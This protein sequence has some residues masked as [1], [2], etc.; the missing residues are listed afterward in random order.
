MNNRKQTL[1]AALCLLFGVGT[2][3]AVAQTDK[4]SL[5]SNPSF[6]SG[7]VDWSVLQMWKQTNT[8]FAK[9]GNVY[10]EKWVSQGSRAGDAQMFQTI[11]NMPNGRYQLVVAAQNVQQN[12]TAVQTGAWIVANDSRVEV[13]E[14]GDYTVEFTVIEKEATIGF[15]AVG[16]TGNY[17]CCDNFRL[18]LLDDDIAVLKA[19]LQNRIDAAEELLEQRLALNTPS[20][21]I[22]DFQAAIDAAKAE[23][24][25]DTDANYVTVAMALKRV[26]LAF[27][28]A[29]ATGTVPAV[30][31]HSYVARGATMAFGRST[32]SGVSSSELLEQGFCWATHPEPTV[33]DNRSTKY[34]TQNGRIYM[35]DN[36]TPS[37][38]YYVRAY[39]MTK[40][41]AVGY[42][43]AVK[44][45]TLPKGNVGWSYNN[46]GSAEENVRINIAVADAVYYLNQ[47]TSINGLYTQVNYGSGTPTADCS[48]GGWMRVGPNA[49]YQ[50]TGTILHEL[51][52]AI[53]VGQHD[54]W[55]GGN[56]PLR[57]G[58][59][60]GDWLGERA[61]AV[62]RFLDN[63]TTS[64]M[65]GDDVHMWPYGINGAH[66]D[67]DAPMLHMSSV[68]IF[69]ALG[70]DGLPPTGGFATPAYTFEQEDTVKYYI[71]NESED[72]GLYTSYLVVENGKVV[73]KA[74]T[75]DDAVA[76]DAAAWYVTFNPQ[77]SYYQLR[78]ASTG[79][80][81]AHGG[82]TAT[83]VS[84]NTNFHMMR[85]RVD[86][87]VGNA[88]KKVNVRGYWLVKPQHSLN[89]PC[90]SAAADGKV[91]SATFD[92]TDGAHAQRWVFLTED[93][94]EEVEEAA[95]G[96]FMSELDEWTLR[97]EAFMNTPHT[98][99]V[100]GTDAAFKVVLDMLKEKQGQ[101]LTTTEIAACV[102]EA[103]A[104]ILEF[105][106]NVTPTDVNQPFDITYLIANAAI[107]DA[108]GWS[109][110]PTLNHS[111]MEYY[112]TVFDFNQ[113]TTAKLPKGVY[114]L[115]VQ[116]FQRPG[117]AATVYDA[118]T[119]GSAI[120][121]SEIY[122]TSS[123]KQKVMHIAA[124][125]QK[126]KLG[127]TESAV[128]S[129][130]RYIPND[131]LAA[132]RYFKNGLYENV[133][134]MKNRRVQAFTLGIRSESRGSMF[135]TVF[136][137]FRLYYYGS[138]EL[139]DVKNGVNG[140][141]TPDA[142]ESIRPS[143]VYSITGKCVRFNATSLEGLPAGLYI[144]GG[145]KV[146][147]K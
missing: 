67:T 7:M 70:E 127:G 58:S 33:L 71:K 54:I 90:L 136:D 61:T 103:K 5:I 119:N 24:A 143:N 2:P 43:D 108:S 64:V 8:S 125:A 52:H 10:M 86:V 45:I 147:V 144:V 72:Y 121:T 97:L 28:L 32:V 118:Y 116:A 1:I 3:H 95:N 25:G 75:G 99:S 92:L 53:G 47:L 135:W 9:A 48:Y 34:H 141:V 62:V 102:E 114:Q 105:L 123:S 104:A 133:L 140:I 94:L 111:C 84:D 112:E 117:A 6:E 113:T 18:Y 80:Y 81:M 26:S 83:T 109:D 131:M 29:N 46:G 101:T 27:R 100:E 78:N 60:R 88:T 42:G 98:E 15:E 59:G 91:T 130:T 120:V 50:R 13:N 107:D 16:A 85:S 142:E 74:M 79:V 41:Y 138:M 12:S 87:T 14:A 57:A 51:G 4:T 134:T 69:Q 129:P 39:A 110:A 65:T 115:R 40:D 96:A 19:E 77:N 128:G 30:S 21:G 145:R 38:K 82:A 68:L 106:P 49:S 17:L 11:K 44:V 146:I 36:L 89:P 126:S 73:W 22:D 35:M 132:S 23:L 20:E 37:T 76:D 124:E 31:T 139:D 122:L 137:N 63:S 93:E 55:Y 56:S 66:E